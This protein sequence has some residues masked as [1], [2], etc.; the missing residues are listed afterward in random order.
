MF[1]KK[2]GAFLPRRLLPIMEHKEVVAVCCTSGPDGW[3]RGMPVIHMVAA[4]PDRIMM[5]LPAKAQHAGDLRRDGRLTL[6]FLE[7]GD[8]VFVVRGQASLARDS[9]AV[10][11]ELAAFLVTV[12]EAIELRLPGFIVSQ[13]VRVEKKGHSDRVIYRQILQELHQ[14]ASEKAKAEGGKNEKEE[15]WIKPNE[16]CREDAAEDSS[17]G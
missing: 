12:V 11:E 14:L 13:G 2:A 6:T 3:A 8:C 4:G 5:A 9:L 15:E 17:H 10:A 7:E 1:W 16:G